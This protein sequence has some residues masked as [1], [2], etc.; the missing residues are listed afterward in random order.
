[1]SLREQLHAYIARLEERLRWNTWL[2]GLA[3]F[4]GSALLATL[5]LVSIDL[6]TSSVPALRLH[7][8]W[9]VRLE[10]NITAMSIY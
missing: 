1:M 10:L 8:K 5:V 2:R 4:A 3:I 9:L 7:L 6:S